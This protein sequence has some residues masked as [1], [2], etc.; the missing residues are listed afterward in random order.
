MIGYKSLAGSSTATVEIAIGETEEFEG[1]EIRVHA[2]NVGIDLI[3][4]TDQAGVPYTNA[5][6]SAPIDGNLFAVALKTEYNRLLFPTPLHLPPG[7]RL[8]FQ[9][10]DTSTATNEVFILLMGKMR[11]VG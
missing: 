6:S 8:K 2:T 3:S 10:T 5:T 4:I 7:T 1:D 9:I 11:T